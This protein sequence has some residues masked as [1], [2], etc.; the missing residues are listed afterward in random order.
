MGREVNDI[1]VLARL[2][3]DISY[4]AEPALK[5][6]RYQFDDDIFEFLDHANDAES[7]ELAALAQR[8]LVNSHYAAVNEFLDRHP[9]TDHEEAAC[10]YFLFL[11]MDYARLEFDSTA[12]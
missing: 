10:L 5:Y 6:G 7:T 1:G 2:P 8:V 3:A 9:I 11:V 12:D 4:L